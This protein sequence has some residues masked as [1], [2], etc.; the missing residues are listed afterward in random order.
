MEVLEAFVKINLIRENGFIILK[1]TVKPNIE[2]NLA[3]PLAK[4]MTSG[5]FHHARLHVGILFREIPLN[6]VN[7]Q[8]RNSIQ[9]S[10]EIRICLMQKVTEYPLGACLMVGC[11]PVREGSILNNQ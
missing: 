7:N 3:P 10:R 6:L 4:V 1:T 5:S 2:R 8:R 11:R 9:G